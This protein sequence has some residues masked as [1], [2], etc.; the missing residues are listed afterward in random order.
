MQRV[1]LY[2]D[3]FRP[4]RDPSDAA[5]LAAALLVL[6][7]ALV[8]VSA[9]QA[10]RLETAR[11]GVAAAERE[12]EAAQQRLDKLRGEL[13]AATGD[14]EQTQQRVERLRNELAAKREL[15]TFLESG[16]LASDAGF[17]QY[18]EGLAERV[19][20]GVWLE[21]IQ[22]AQNAKRIRL[23]GHALRPAQVPDFMAALGQAEAYEG[24]T[25]R[26]LQLKRS[27]DDADG[28]IEFLL[29]SQRVDEE[30][31]E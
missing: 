4:R 3:H 30:S 19:V 10:W 6:V 14:D 22:L 1:N 21:R 11:D 18:L 7:L 28:A 27:K 29:A 17:S 9:Y 13:E 8:A 31:D 20:D 25:F 2:Q 23:D 24:R 15:L 26:T 12:Q 16:P 5:H